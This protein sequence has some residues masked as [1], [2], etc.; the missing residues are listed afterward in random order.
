[1]VRREPE[2]DLPQ[3]D[4]AS[5]DEPAAAQEGPPTGQS[6]SRGASSARAACRGR[7]SSARPPLRK[8]GRAA[9]W[10]SGQLRSR[11][12]DEDG[13]KREERDGRVDGDVGDPRQISGRERDDRLGIHWATARPSTPPAA[14]TSTTR[15]SQARMAPRLRRAPGGSRLRGAAVRSRVSMRPDTLAQAISSSTPT[16]ATAR[17]GPDERGRRRDRQRRRDVLAPHF[18]RRRPPR[19]DGL[20]RRPLRRARRPGRGRHGRGPGRR[21]T[22]SVSSSRFG[23]R[24]AGRGTGTTG[25]QSSAPRGKSR[26]GRPSHP[27]SPTG[28]IERHRRATTLGS[29]RSG[30]PRRRGSAPRPPGR[31]ARRLQRGKSGEQRTGAERA[32]KPAETPLI[33]DARRLAASLQPGAP[34]VRPHHGRAREGLAGCVHSRSAGRSARSPPV[35]RRRFARRTARFSGASTGSGRSNTVLTALKMALLAPIASAKVRIAVAA[36]PG[37][38]RR[39]RNA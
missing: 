27:R 6:G 5:Q 11:A 26:P 23:R 18:R 35:R 3:R 12:H 20:R 22:P 34:V 21:R 8:A 10:R 1:M 37:D 38:C 7:R 19:Q 17:A 4:K 24:A 31:W 36:Y 39:C 9:A 32:E 15:T 2:I 28:F 14:A 25:I 33:P 16:A 13:G 29:E 30:A